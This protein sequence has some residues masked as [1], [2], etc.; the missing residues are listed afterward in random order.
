[1]CSVSFTKSKYTLFQKI[2]IDI[3]RTSLH[4]RLLSMLIFFSFCFLLIYGVQSYLHLKPRSTDVFFARSVQW[5]LLKIIKKYRLKCYSWVAYIMFVFSS[6]VS[7]AIVGLIE[8]FLKCWVHWLISN[9]ICM[10]RNTLWIL[11]INWIYICIFLYCFIAV[12]SYW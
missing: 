12:I 7:N 9:L 3:N 2:A 11:K 1:M 5:F 8:Y 6:I 4:Q 10:A